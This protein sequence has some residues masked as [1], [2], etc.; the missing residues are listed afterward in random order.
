MLIQYV[1]LG[2]SEVDSWEQLTTL[3]Q[4]TGVISLIACKPL[5]NIKYRFP[6]LSVLLMCLLPLKALA[7]ILTFCSDAKSDN[8]TYSVNQP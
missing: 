7:S 8:N 3:H 1:L 5:E 2:S 6:I 4:E